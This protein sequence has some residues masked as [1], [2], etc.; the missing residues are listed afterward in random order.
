MVWSS[1]GQVRLRADFQE[2]KYQWLLSDR[3]GKLVGRSKQVGG[4]EDFELI[5]WLVI[6]G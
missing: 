2:K 3:D 4:T 1:V 6:K 5:T